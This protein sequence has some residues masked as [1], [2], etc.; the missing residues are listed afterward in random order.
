MQVLLQDSFEQMLYKDLEK[1]KSWRWAKSR[2]L[3]LTHIQL[4]TMEH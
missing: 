4:R 3:N 2:F 1:D